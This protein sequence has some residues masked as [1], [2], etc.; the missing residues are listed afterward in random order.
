[1]I[2]P[3]SRYTQG[4]LV[5]LPNALGVYNLSV[6]RT[7]PPSFGQFKLYVWQNGDRPD[8]V[9]STQLNNPQLWWA[10]FDINPEVIDPL[11]VPAGALVRI[12]SGPVMGQ[13]TLTQ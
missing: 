2:L 1:M 9:A 5:R 6:T 12:P 7:V 10:I 3:Q 4:Q 13:G 11:S 8:S